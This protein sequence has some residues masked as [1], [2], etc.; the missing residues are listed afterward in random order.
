MSIPLTPLD[1]CFS[2]CVVWNGTPTRIPIFGPQG[3]E[4]DGEVRTSHPVLRTHRSTGTG[5]DSGL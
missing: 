1:L 4:V 3:H 5:S 2:L